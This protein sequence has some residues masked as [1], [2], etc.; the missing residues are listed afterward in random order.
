[1]TN[2]NILD[3][4]G[5]IN[6]N[7]VQDAK[8]YKRPKSK[9]WFRW[10]AMAACL[11]LVVGIAIPI[12]H[13]K[14]KGGIDHQD[15]LQDTAAFEL[16][17][18]FY[19]VVEN[20]EVLEKYGLPSKIT[21]D[22]AGDHVAYLKSDGDDSYKCTP[23]E[24]DM[25]LYQYNP[26]A[27][28]GVYVL[29]NGETWCAALFCNFYQFDSNT[30][31]SL[32]E[33]YR[34]YGI[35]SA[36]DIKSITEM[37]NNNE[38]ETGTPVVERQEITEFYN[39]TIALGSYGNDDFQAEVFGNIPE[40]KQQ[41]AHTAFADDRRNLRIETA[42]GL[43]FFIAFYPSYNWIYGGGTMSYFKIDNQM[44]NWIERNATIIRS[45][46]TTIEN[47][48]LYWYTDA[49][50][51]DSSQPGSLSPEEA[52]QKLAV[53]FMEDLKTDSE[54]RTFKVTEYKNLS[55]SVMPTSQIDAETAAIYCLREEE[56][57][58]DTWLV[59]I[60]VSYKYEGILSPVGPSNGEWIDILYQASP[61]GFLM[62]KDGNSYSLQ[63]RYS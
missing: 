18:K 41:E 13:H 59:E 51:V 63:S 23:I 19:E 39:M 40:E 31:C 57:S 30:N 53:L 37:D 12:L 45:Y 60:S 61:V 15:P 43:R 6:E 28:D 26:A 52:A 27:S 36:D 3:A 16:N 58:P 1:M 14:G 46:S 5:G 54:E 4:I 10:G 22:V 56:I 55:V 20:P 21:E 49:G 35:E 62:K 42:S 34:V 25:E 24:T 33:L 32:T 8:A 17:G 50:V 44:R 48:T 9:R 38:N 11:C 29:R 47:T 2:E 7:A